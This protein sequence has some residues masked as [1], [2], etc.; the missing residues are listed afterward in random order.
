MQASYR[1]QAT[2][3]QPPA[4]LPHPPSW[5]AFSTGTALVRTVA[6]LELALLQPAAHIE[7]VEHLQLPGANV[8][9]HNVTRATPGRPI[10][11]MVHPDTKSIVVRSAL[12]TLPLLF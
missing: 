10:Q 5:A 9:R 11:L 3:P 1:A 6:E 8:K 4:E 12:Q 7:I 2:A